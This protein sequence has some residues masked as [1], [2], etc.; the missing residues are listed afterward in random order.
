MKTSLSHL[1]GPALKHLG[2]FAF[3]CG[4]LPRS[5]LTA[6]VTLTL[7][8]SGRTDEEVWSLVSHEASLFVTLDASAGTSDVPNGAL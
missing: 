7:I 5:L 4:L 8:G 2:C 3:T 1:L 6:L